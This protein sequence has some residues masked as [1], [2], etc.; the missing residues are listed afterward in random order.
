MGSHSVRRLVV[1]RN[2]LIVLC[3]IRSK[4]VVDMVKQDWS[5]LSTEQISEKAIRALYSPPEIYRIYPNRYDAGVTFPT[6]VARPHVVHILEGS[7]K[8]KQGNREVVLEASEFVS[9]EKGSYSFEVLGSSPVSLVKVFKL[10][11]TDEK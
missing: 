10:P 11:D 5:I 1:Q 8:Y 4:I 2:E 6:T 9:L 3:G 7:C